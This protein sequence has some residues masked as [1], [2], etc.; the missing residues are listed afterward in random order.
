MQGNTSKPVG[1]VRH[2]WRMAIVGWSS[3]L[4]V[5]SVMLLCVRLRVPRIGIALSLCVMPVGLICSALAGMPARP[6]GGLREALLISLSMAVWA[7]IGALTLRL[8]EIIPR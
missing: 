1:W 8:L 4:I 3:W 7:C 6:R 2:P 5:A